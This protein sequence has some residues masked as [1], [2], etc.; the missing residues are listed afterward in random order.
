MRA[1]V[2]ARAL[3]RVREVV[4]CF[5]AREQTLWGDRWNDLSLRAFAH[6]L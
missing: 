5:P 1:C 4:Y 3:M 2:L 6:A